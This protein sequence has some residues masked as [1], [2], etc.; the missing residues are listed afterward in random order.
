VDKQNYKDGE[1]LMTVMTM[2][3]V[4]ESFGKHRLN[5]FFIEQAKL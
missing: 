5:K 3:E 4:G 2:D 1:F